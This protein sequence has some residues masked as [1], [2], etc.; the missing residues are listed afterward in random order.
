MSKVTREDLQKLLDYGMISEEEQKTIFDSFDHESVEAAQKKF[1]SVLQANVVSAEKEE[2][3]L[4]ITKDELLA[5]MKHADSEIFAL[6]IK[7]SKIKA[8]KEIEEYRAQ[9][10]EN[11]KRVGSM[12]LEYKRAGRRLNEL[13]FK[14]QD[15]LNK[16]EI[17]KVRS[18]LKNN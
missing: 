3:E 5:R 18:T 4:E 7:K 16:R 15:V 2:K 12:V 10:A 13:I 1:I 6:R 11:Q 9:K 14:A 8:Q 17:E